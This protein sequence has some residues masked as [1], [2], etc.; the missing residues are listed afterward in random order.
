MS[1]KVQIDWIKWSKCSKLWNSKWKLIHNMCLHYRSCPHGICHRTY[2]LNYSSPLLFLSNLT[3]IREVCAYS[4]QQ[5]YNNPSIVNA[6]NWLSLSACAKKILNPCYKLAI[7]KQAYNFMT[8]LSLQAH[9]SW[10]P[11]ANV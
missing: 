7:E 3:N 9:S 5:Q 11:S 8:I 2:A 10:H 1:N 6:L 4:I